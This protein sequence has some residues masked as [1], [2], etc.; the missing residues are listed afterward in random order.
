LPLS[1]AQAGKHSFFEP[2]GSLGPAAPKE[3]NMKRTFPLWLGLLAFA[4]LPALAQQTTGKIHGHVTNPTGVSATSGKV[5]LSTD[6]GHTSL[7]TFAV[8][9]DGE[10]AGEAAPGTYTV[11]FRML[12]TPITKIVDSFNGVKVVAGGEVVQ[13]FDMS[14]KDYIDKLPAD[15]KQQLTDLKKQ[16]AE[17]VKANE[18]IKGL[19]ADLKTV[20]Q[21]FK[22]AD[23]AAA[24]AA[25]ALGAAATKADIA[26][27]EAEIK[28]AKYTEV[29]T[30]MLKDS[31][32]KPDASI[33]WTQLGQ[34]EVGLKK[35]NDAE[36][37][38]KKALD[39]EAKTSKQNTQVQGLANAGLGEI[40]AR[41]G[42][43]PEA[44]AAYAAAAKTNPSQAAVYLRNEAVIFFHMNNSDAQ[45]AAADEA[46]KIDPNQPVLY[47]LKGQGLISKATVDPKTHKIVLPPGCGEAY[48]KYLALAPTGPYAGEV[49][50][51]LAQASQTITVTTKSGKK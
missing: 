38:F 33:L 22:D 31:A 15:V 48:E 1:S 35:Y 5:S 28:L 42:K 24:T 6:G 43:V 17:A 11:V 30:L 10:Y 7:F 19:N 40:Y 26:A 51:I 46:I 50:G 39:L 21:D 9:A 16:N 27:K 13:D 29:E 14:R 4:L 25:K 45:V 34:A 44:N 47:Y 49:K 41:S 8:S 37:N 20:I 3:K 32:A 12:D 18:V 23:S 2:A 36:P